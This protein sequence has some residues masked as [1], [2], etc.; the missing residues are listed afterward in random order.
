M[1][2][3]KNLLIKI[4]PR[5]ITDFW[6]KHRLFDHFTYKKDGLYTLHNSSFMEDEDFIKAYAEGKKTGSWGNYDIEWRVHIV[7]YYAR[8]ASALEGDFVE[9]GVNKGGLS[10]AIVEDIDFNETGKIFYLFDTFQGFDSSVLSEAEKLKYAGLTHYEDTYDHVKNIFKNFPAVKIIKG[11]VP[12]T[13]SEVTIDK[14]SFVSIDMNCVLPEKEALDFFWPRLVKGG[15]IVLDDFAYQSFEEQ[16]SAHK[17]WAKERGVSI[18]FLPTG[19]GI[20]M[21]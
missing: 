7:L 21:K 5:I 6:D 11:T 3:L 14:V 13:L 4:L 18:L 9:C 15:V 2:T 20:I 16:N 19:Q 8:Y 10:R 1:R 17:K 12:K